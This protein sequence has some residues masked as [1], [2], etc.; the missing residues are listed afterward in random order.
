M[1]SSRKTKPANPLHARPDGSRL[2]SAWLTKTFAAAEAAA[3]AVRERPD[4]NTYHGATLLRLNPQG[5]AFLPGNTVEDNAA[6]LEQMANWGWPGGTSLPAWACL[7][8]WHGDAAL[9]WLEKRL[10]MRLKSNPDTIRLI[11][12][13]AS[14]AAQDALLRHLDLP[15]V[16]AAVA[17]SAVRWPLYTLRGLLALDPRRGQPA[18]DLVQRLLFQHPDWLA[19][20]EAQLET[21]GDDAQAKTL[22][23]LLTAVEQV[24]EASADELPAMLRQPP[25]GKG[26]S[27][28]QVPA[29]DITP[30]R[31]PARIDWSRWQGGTV[32]AR[33]REIYG[34]GRIS[35]EA[36]MEKHIGLPNSQHEDLVTARAQADAENWG[37]AGRALYLLGIRRERVTTLLAGDTLRP[38]DFRPSVDWLGN[39]LNHLGYLDDP[40]ALALLGAA[41]TG[42]WSQDHTYIW[43]TD[44]DEARNH[45]ARL[46]K[47]F[48]AE[49]VDLLLTIRPPDGSENSRRLLDIVDWDGLALWLS[50]RGM[51]LRTMRANAVHWL[52]R[53]PD[54]T[55][56]ALIPEALS[57]DPKRHAHARFHLYLLARH[58]HSPAIRAQA[59]RYGQAVQDTVEH[60]LNTPPENLLPAQLPKLPAWLNI[61]RLPRLRL[62]GSD[63]AVPLSHMAD[64]LMPLMLSKGG[65]AYAGLDVL[66]AAVTPDSLA[67]VLLDL[68]EQ[69]VDNDM[70][71]KDRW[72]FELQGRL[73]DDGNARALAPRIREW[74]SHLDRV[75]TYE[76]LEML[77]QIGSDASL[78]L[79]TA[80][81]EQKRYTDLQTHA[82]R[83]L[84]RI[85]DERGL[86]IDE[87]ADRTV[88]TLGLDERA[89]LLLDF[90]PRQFTASL[91]AQLQPQVHD[92]EGARLK[93]L[94]KPG[95]KD[96]ATLA[97]AASADW[98]EF[99]KNAKLVAST[100]T[101]RL[102][103]A[104]C[105]QR[106]W[107]AADFMAL[108]VQH[109]VLRTL[110]QRLVWAA[111]DAQG[112]LA[113]SFRVSEDL[114]L[115]DTNSDAY[116]LP[117]GARVGLPH[118]LELPEGQR[119]RWGAHLADFELTQPFEQ[120]ARATHALAE[121]EASLN[122]LPRYAGRKLSTGS[123]VGLEARGWKREVGDGGTIYSLHKALDATH[124]AALHFEPGWFVGAA[125]PTDEQQHITGVH[126]S[127]TTSAPAGGKPL[128]PPA[129]RD[130]P[131]IAIS[132][133]LRDLERLAWHQH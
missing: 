29:L 37:T 103:N 55:A 93:D 133:M 115:I 132:E 5:T 91:D 46:L 26:T 90:G 107:L 20:L 73:G 59:V 105:A 116:A 50:E 25:W 84:R 1:A 83:A 23:R 33:P 111:F 71:A 64:A 106:R 94:P 109:P 121:D 8:D 10:D 15:E 69:W 38:A 127:R 39:K 85:A 44:V 42:H 18:A 78:M 9:P 95:A 28:A 70:P 81:T 24:T 79:L 89:R 21:D 27:A 87:L 68:F 56:R 54:T 114:S 36:D 92:A 13:L 101:T 30:L 128:P 43:G 129:W 60:L 125:A 31:E 130:L 102:E 34:N 62:V 110:C 19:A 2:R 88:P 3:A 52:L 66:Q 4:P 100:Q 118:P 65:A 22:A 124:Q 86:S 112:Q 122:A 126:L 14:P 17:E 67:R 74:R 49:H 40:L 16:R 117:N 113:G 76:G 108:F 119:N 61:P 98:R 131:A 51:R 32:E 123:L 57:P 120:V 72:I 97:K 58:G 82:A 41:P 6:F 7:L 99:K 53:H 48:G 45:A 11:A 75:R 80:F 35:V 12:S 104:M 96:S 77:A 63:H 47:R